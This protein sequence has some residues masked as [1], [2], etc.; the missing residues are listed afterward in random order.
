MLNSQFLSPS[1]QEAPKAPSFLKQSD[2][3][4]DVHSINL[5][6]VVGTGFLSPWKMFTMWEKARGL[7]RAQ[8]VPSARS[9]GRS[10]KGCWGPSIL[11]TAMAEDRAPA[12]CMGFQQECDAGAK[13]MFSRGSAKHTVQMLDA[14]RVETEPGGQMNGPQQAIVTNPHQAINAS[15]QCAWTPKQSSDGW[16]KSETE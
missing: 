14:I 8:E 7:G 5:S 2:L 11:G 9:C 15:P 12:G 10:L 4:R 16:D 3:K 1:P 6:E 13:C